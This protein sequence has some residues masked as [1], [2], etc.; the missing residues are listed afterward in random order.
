MK[1]G[2]SIWALPKQLPSVKHPNQEIA[3]LNMGEKVLQTIRVNVH[4]PP[5]KQAR[6]KYARHFS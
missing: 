5:P 1:S 6:P 4:N 2:P 3:H